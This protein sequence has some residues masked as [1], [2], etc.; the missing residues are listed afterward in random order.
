VGSGKDRTRKRMEYGTSWRVKGG[1]MHHITQSLRVLAQGGASK[2]VSL[3]GTYGDSEV[4]S[5]S[6]ERRRR[7]SSW[8]VLICHVDVGIK[9]DYQRRDAAMRDGGRVVAR[10]SASGSLAVQRWRAELMMMQ[11][12]VGALMQSRVKVADENPSSIRNQ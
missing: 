7:G 6:V 4:E 10:L 11:S 5:D 3:P 1:I 8:I 12:Q 9:S 2:L